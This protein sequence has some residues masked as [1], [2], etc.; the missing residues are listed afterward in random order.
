[1]KLPAHHHL[2]LTLKTQARYLHSHV[3]R[4]V[5]KYRDVF[6]YYVFIHNKRSTY[7]VKAH[8]ILQR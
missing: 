4:A 8:L 6:N 7:V 1:V 2:M 5:F 3:R